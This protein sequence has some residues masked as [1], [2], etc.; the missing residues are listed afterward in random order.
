MPSTHA[1]QLEVNLRMLQL[2][3]MVLKL[4]FVAHIQGCFWYGIAAA[5]LDED[6]EG[7]TWVSAYS[8][9]PD[10]VPTTSECY[11]WS[12]YWAITTLTTVGYGDITPANNLERSYSCVCLIVGALIMANLIS[13]LSALMML[14]SIP[15]SP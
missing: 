8:G 14:H 13:E 15:Y 3:M 7:E 2:V 6:G 1:P 4:L 11:L 9:D 12:I 10:Y 5:S